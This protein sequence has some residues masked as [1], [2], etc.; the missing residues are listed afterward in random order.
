MEF[1]DIQ[2]I[3]FKYNALHNVSAKCEFVYFT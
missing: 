3:L 1:I 2:I